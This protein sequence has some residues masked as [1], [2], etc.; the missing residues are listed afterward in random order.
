MKNKFKTK[1]HFRKHPRLGY[2]PVQT[3]LEGDA[4]ER[5]VCLKITPRPLQR[6]YTTSQWCIRYIAATKDW[7]PCKCRYSAYLKVWMQYGLKNFSICIGENMHVFDADTWLLW[8]TDQLISLNN[9]STQLLRPPVF[10]TN[11]PIS[12]IWYL[13]VLLLRLI[14]YK[15]HFFVDPKCGLI[16]GQTFSKLSLLFSVLV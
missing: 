4:L 7:H 10:G 15:D 14:R 9:Q 8:S 1:R 16:C 3:V 13:K 5:W 12:M 6:G 2:L 11:Q